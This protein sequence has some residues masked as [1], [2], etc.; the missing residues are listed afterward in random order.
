[1]TALETIKT[2]ICLEEAAPSHEFIA[3]KMYVR[4]YDLAELLP[5]VSLSSYLF[6]LFFEE[7]P[8]PAQKQ[9]LDALAVLLANPGPRDPSVLAAMTAAAAGATQA[10]SLISAIAAGA[11]VCGGSR[12]IFY[13]DQAW[14]EC[15]INAQ[16]WVDYLPNFNWAQP[17][18]TFAKVEHILGFMPYEGVHNSWATEALEQLLK[19]PD[20]GSF[21]HLHFLQQQLPTFQTA[22]NR[23]ISVSLIASA[24]LRDLGCNAEQAEMLYLLLRLP[25]AAAHAYEQRVQGITEFPFWPQ[26]I[27]YQSD[28]S[29]VV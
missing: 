23:T 25:G 11:G 8:T 2:K 6:L 14:R 16:A 24:A 15:G 21:M 10:A 26:G 4:G 19:L 7:L 28:N 20:A 17:G 3:Q 22:F 27:H 9:L 18:E 5:N 29:T 1:M 13:L 12:E